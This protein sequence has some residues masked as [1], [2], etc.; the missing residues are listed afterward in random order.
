MTIESKEQHTQMAALYASGVT[1]FEIGRRYSLSKERIRQILASLGVS[2][3]SGGAAVRRKL[4]R[5]LAAEARAKKFFDKYGCTEEQFYTVK[6]SHHEGAKAPLYAFFR[7]RIHARKRGI[8][9]KLSFWEWWCIWDKSG[10]W[11]ARGRCS[12]QYVMCRNGD[13]GAYEVGNVHIG[14]C[15]SNISYGRTLAWE[16]GGKNT[17]TLKVIKAAGGRKL[18]AKQLGYKISFISHIGA[19]NGFPPNWKELGHLKKLSEMTLGLFTERELELHCLSVKAR[20]GS[21]VDA[22]E[23]NNGQ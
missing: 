4:E 11:D 6:G 13:V 7:Q 8:E 17:F 9:W 18:V 14:T 2:G 15:N 20:S 10:K 1:M 22:V 5:S 3:G 23:A 12:D 19:I 16:T 21:V